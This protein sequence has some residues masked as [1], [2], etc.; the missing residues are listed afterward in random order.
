MLHWVSSRRRRQG[1]RLAAPVRSRRRVV[2]DLSERASGVG[3]LRPSPA[4]YSVGDAGWRGASRRCRCPRR[5]VLHPD[6]PVFDLPRRA[7]GQLYLGREPHRRVTQVCW[8]AVPAT[9]A[10]SCGNA[11]AADLISPR[12]RAGVP[13]GFPPPD[14]S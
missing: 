9:P 10:L 6:L 3:A 12:L 7:G 8:W 5:P 1:S 2:D 11:A 13:S 14:A 4:S